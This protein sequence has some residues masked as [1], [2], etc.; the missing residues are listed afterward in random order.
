MVS[1]RSRWRGGHPRWDRQPDYPA[2]GVDP[3]P[4]KA[5]GDC[6]PMERS[7][8]GMGDCFAAASLE[9]RG[10]AASHRSRRSLEH[11]AARTHT[12][13][14]TTKGWRIQTDRDAQE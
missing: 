8:A 13:Y 1:G 9:F 3:P 5:E 2:R 14:G 4:R 10:A 7:H 12:T 11:E 6:G